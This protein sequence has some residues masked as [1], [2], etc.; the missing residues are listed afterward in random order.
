[1]EG[2]YQTESKTE[3]RPNS[4]MHDCDD[5]VVVVIVV[6]ELMNYYSFIF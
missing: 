6:P 5:A 2:E 3:N 4:K 1:L